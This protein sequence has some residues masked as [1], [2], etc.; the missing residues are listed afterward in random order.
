LFA[1]TLPQAGI[2]AR[3]LLIALQ[4]EFSITAQFRRRSAGL[5]AGTTTA[6]YLTN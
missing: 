4:G 2:D 6:F 1:A 3:R 5:C